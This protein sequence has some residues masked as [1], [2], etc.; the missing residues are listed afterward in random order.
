MNTPISSAFSIASIFL[1]NGILRSLNVVIVCIIISRIQY[2]Q[3][4]IKLIRLILA[5]FR[6]RLGILYRLQLLDRLGNP[7]SALRFVSLVELL[8]E[9]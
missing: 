5:Q 4:C 8:V 3:L 7:L 6:K 9:Q 2:L 1:D